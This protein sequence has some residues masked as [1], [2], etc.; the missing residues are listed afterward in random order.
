MVYKHILQMFLPVGHIGHYKA[1][2]AHQ[3]CGHQQQRLA[4][5]SHQIHH[6]WVSQ[7]HH[8][9]AQGL[10]RVFSLYPMDLLRKYI[11]ELSLHLHLVQVLNSHQAP[12]HLLRGQI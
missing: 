11:V 4:Q 5:L 12:K 3:L 6:Y 1:T 7:D 10:P 8:L 9:K 2:L